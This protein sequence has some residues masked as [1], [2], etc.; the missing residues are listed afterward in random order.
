MVAGAADQIV[1]TGA[2]AAQNNSEISGEVELV[3]AGRAALVETNDPE[4]MA[5]EVF[6]GAHQIDDAGDAQVLSG[7]GAGFKSCSAQGR[8]AALGEDNTVDA[9]SIG[10]AKQRAEIL[11]IFDA[12]ER[13]NEARHVGFGG[14]GNEK[15]FDRKEFL[16]ANQRDDALVRRGLG[17]LR[18][19]VARLGADANAGLATLFDEA[20]QAVIVA[21]AGDEDVIE[22]AAA[23]LEC[24]LDRMQAVEDFHDVSLVGVKP[25]TDIG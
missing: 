17:D 7:T 19:L 5:L 8:G 20:L 4:V 24:F 25:V 10:N 23:G 11:R 16:R 12:V 3:V 22:A 18:E 15:V 6:E 1:K 21:L 14:V 13:K 2:F 9:R